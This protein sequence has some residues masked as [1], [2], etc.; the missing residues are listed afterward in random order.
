MD[1]NNDVHL[2]VC[3]NIESVLKIEYEALPE[4]TD[5]MCIIGLDNSII[6]VKQRFGFGKNETVLRHP[7]IDGIVAQVV[8]IAV[9]YVDQ[10]GSL[11]VKDFVALVGTI[12]K[13]VARHAEFGPRA[14]YEFIRAYV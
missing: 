4:L 13:S 14:Y 9:G 12:K 10:G 2:S 11:S 5:G 7:A 1:M 8:D 3:Q 6:A